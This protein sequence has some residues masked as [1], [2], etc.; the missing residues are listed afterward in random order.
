MKTVGID[1][2]LY[3]QTGVGT[4]LR[5]LLANLALF[6]RVAQSGGTRSHSASI[7]YT[8]F[9]RAEDVFHI[10][11]DNVPGELVPVRAA[12][13]SFAEQTLFLNEVLSRRV[14]LMHFPYFSY[15][16]LYPGQ[17]LATVHDLT[18][19]KFRTGKASRR[20]PL[21][22][23]VKHKVF[24]IVLETQIRRA[25]AIVTPTR[26]V[27]DEIG[28]TFGST[29]AA[30][31]HPLYE[32]VHA[33]L[34][35]VSPRKPYSFA[36]DETVPYA[37]YVGNFYPHKNVESLV[38]AFK[39]VP[40]RLRLVLV[41]PEDYFARGIREQIQMCGLM[42]RVTLIHAAKEAE[43]VYLYRGA[44]M[45]VHASRSEGFGLPLIE[46]AYFN[47]PVVASNIRVFQ[48]LLGTAYTPFDQENPFDIAEKISNVF[49]QPKTKTTVDLAR[50][51]FKRMSR[52]HELL[53]S[54]LLGV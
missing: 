47:V 3:Y 7:N 35:R 20:N 31:C 2:R 13:H 36:W 5:N 34:L 6:R 29:A 48:E 45:F 43:L 25:A 44:R 12:W 10:R 8:I 41:G 46:A 32:G 21:V 51:D 24:S 40:K 33:D 30:K 42:D 38:A 18:P 17:F 4:Y 1:A 14:D 53:Y 19:L 54:K 16:V 49:L 52:Q 37:L 27:R 9:V 26:T 39:Y 11:P 15:P 28:E 50:F 22:Y 23:A